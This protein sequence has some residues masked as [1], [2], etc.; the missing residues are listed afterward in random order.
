[1][2]GEVLPDRY[3]FDVDP[4]GVERHFGVPPAALA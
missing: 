3:R 2:I 1:M 4:N